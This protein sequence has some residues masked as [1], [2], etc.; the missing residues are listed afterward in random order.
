MH[1][2]TARTARNVRFYTRCGFAE[3]GST[4]WN[5]RDVLFLAKTLGRPAAD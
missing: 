5:G 3:Q 2:V 4:R 1:V